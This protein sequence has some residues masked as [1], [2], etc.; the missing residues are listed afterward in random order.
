M[1]AAGDPKH[2][3]LSTEVHGITPHKMVISKARTLKESLLVVLY[4]EACVYSLIFHAPSF[5][6]SSVMMSLFTP[7][8]HH[9]RKGCPM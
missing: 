7:S 3:S 2:W 1:K 6:A 5:S 8:V 4:V 9:I